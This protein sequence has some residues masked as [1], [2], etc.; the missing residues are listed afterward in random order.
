MVLLDIVAPIFGVVLAGYAMAR[1]R[2]LSPEGVRG[3]SDF[4]FYAAIPALLF[5]TMASAHTPAGAD[6]ALIATYLLACALVFGASMLATGALFRDGVQER[7]VLAMGAAF[8]NSVQLGIPLVL[9]AFG[10]AG[11]VQ[12]MLIV[13][14]HSAT[15]I[16][17]AT[18]VIEGAREGGRSQR[19]PR[20]AL[21]RGLALAARSI[22]TNPII[23]AMFA[24]IAC[25]ALGWSLPGPVD[26][27]VALIAGG[28]A[29]CALFA[30]GASL[31]QFKLGGRLGE[32]A[33][34]GVLKL[35]ALPAVTWALGRFAFA[36]APLPLAVAT[37]CAGL[38]SGVNVF[39]L[40]QRY[41]VA[42]ERSVNLIV[43]STL[44]SLLT[45]SVL[46]AIFAPR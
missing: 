14:F 23:L 2:L 27:F 1:G 41:G 16:T 9:Q 3:I 13:S 40:A 35:L 46:L 39:I 5:R 42:V 37:V 34:V 12:L 38:P 20:L 17:L 4:V 26:R 33:V 11:L 18:V 10:D 36:L 19:P 21:A 28:S 30:M 25:A 29:A 32:S 24:G 7:G 8:S 22:V 31:A 15:L 45:L 6:L 44:A 43:L